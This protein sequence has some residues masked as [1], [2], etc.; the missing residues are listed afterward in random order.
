MMQNDIASF[1]TALMKRG[2]QP[3]E[4]K[5]V[6]GKLT[7]AQVLHALRATAAAAA[8]WEGGEVFVYYTGHGWYSGDSAQTARP[9]LALQRDPDAKSALFWDEVFAA[10]RLPRGVQLILLP[11]C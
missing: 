9:A 7:R 2:L 8:G 5:E 10:L 1:R 3:S 4:I 6:S 11:D